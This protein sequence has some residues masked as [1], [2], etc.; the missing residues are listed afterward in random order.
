MKTDEALQEGI[1]ALRDWLAFL[2]GVENALQAQLARARK[3]AGDGTTTTED[4]SP[5]D[6]EDDAWL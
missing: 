6:D 1:L 2:E 3:A 5:A 4:E